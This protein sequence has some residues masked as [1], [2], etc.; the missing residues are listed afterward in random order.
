MS[1]AEES[2]NQGDSPGVILL[3]VVLVAQTLGS[4]DQVTFDA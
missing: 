3:Y 1:A 4:S 2:E